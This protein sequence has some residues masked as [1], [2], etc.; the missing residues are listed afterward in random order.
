MGKAV[1]RRAG[2]QKETHRGS[3]LSSL[4]PQ[5][6]SQDVYITRQET[7]MCPR[8]T[9]C[10]V[11]TRAASLTPHRRLFSISLPAGDRQPCS[12]PPA[13]PAPAA[14]TFMRLPHRI[15]STDAVTS[16]HLHLLAKLVQATLVFHLP[17]GPGSP[18]YPRFI[19]WEPEEASYNPL[20]HPT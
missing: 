6:A 2:S 11:S 16:P 5:E 8:R 4:G 20:T 19:S 14:Q 12:H 15:H 18:P 13:H 9:A 7:S 1:L 17:P 3:M 10:V